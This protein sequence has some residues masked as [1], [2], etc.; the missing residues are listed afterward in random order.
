M[1]ISARYLGREEDIICFVCKTKFSVA[2]GR[3]Q[4]SDSILSRKFRNLKTVLSNHL[5]SNI[6]KAEC[7]KKVAVETLEAKQDSRVASI[8]LV[9]VSI[10]YLILKRGRPYED[11]TD[12]VS[13]LAKLHVDVGEINHS[14]QFAGKFRRRSAEII[15]KRWKKHLSTRCPQTGCLPPA[16]NSGRYGN[17]PT[18]DEAGHWTCHSHARISTVNS[19]SNPWISKDL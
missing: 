1:Q 17:P 2:D 8:G 3:N 6:H 9:L 7:G 15:Q 4:I 5:E 19:N 18:L 11:Y 10:C 12:L 16:K 14:F 13:L